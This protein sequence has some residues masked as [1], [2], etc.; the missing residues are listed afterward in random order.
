MNVTAQALVF[1]VALSAAAAAIGMSLADH[2]AQ[3]QE[4]IKFE[5]VVVVGIRTNEQAAMG[6]AKLPRVLIEGRRTVPTNVQVADA[7]P[8]G[9]TL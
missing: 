7:N 2:T 5:R 4:I 6:V 1:A 8:M 9:K 3:P